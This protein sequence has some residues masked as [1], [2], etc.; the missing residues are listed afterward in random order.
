MCP[1]LAAAALAGPLAAAVI[2]RA[3]GPASATTAA[4]NPVADRDLHRRRAPRAPA[5]SLLSTTFLCVAAGPVPTGAAMLPASRPPGYGASP[6]T[7]TLNRS[8]TW[9]HR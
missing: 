1:V 9:P 4:A 8:A 5:V 2:P 7:A 3:A 6:L